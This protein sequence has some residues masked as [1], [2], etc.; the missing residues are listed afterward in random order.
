M[1]RPR[2]VLAP[3]A[4]LPPLVTPSVNFP[5]DKS[6]ASVDWAAA[7]QVASRGFVVAQ[8]IASR[9]R[10]A[11]GEQPLRG[12]NAVDG[13]SPPEFP[14][15]RQ[16]LTSWLDF[17]PTTLVTSIK[18]GKHCGFGLFIIL[19]VFGCVLDHMDPDPG[20][21]DL[22]DAKF[23]ARP[24]RLPDPAIPTPVEPWRAPAM[25]GVVVQQPTP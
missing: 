4:T 24:L 22:F 18:L 7:A 15:S 19:P 9:Q 11:T 3:T 13:S 21:G 17:D 20:R 2:S 12:P 16:P 1:H 6:Q 10:N 14:W 25:D 5:A 8:E 23:A